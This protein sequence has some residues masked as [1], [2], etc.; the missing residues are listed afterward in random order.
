MDQ[1]RRQQWRRQE[2]QVGRCMGQAAPRHAPVCRGVKAL[3]DLCG[4][5][6]PLLSPQPGGWG[7]G[8]EGQALPPRAPPS[9]G[10]SQD[11]RP[12][13]DYYSVI[14][15]RKMNFF[16]TLGGPFACQLASGHLWSL[17]S[18]VFTGSRGSLA[19]V[20]GTAGDDRGCKREAQSP[21]TC[22]QP[23][24]NQPAPLRSCCPCSWA[25]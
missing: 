5:I 22:S 14:E 7:P 3:L 19:P 18:L 2:D 15:K 17:P 4:C 11:C 12:K 10:R 13:V 1:W 16:L 6:C 23:W 8:G 25:Y 20:S 24:S 21:S 9:Q